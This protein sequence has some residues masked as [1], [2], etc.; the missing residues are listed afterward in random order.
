MEDG[1]DTVRHKDDQG[2]AETSRSY[3]D[4]L[5]IV[6]SIDE[7]TVQAWG[8]NR[9]N[10]SHKQYFLLYNGLIIKKESAL[11][12]PP[13]TSIVRVVVVKVDQ[14]FREPPFSLRKR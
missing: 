8:P 9:C 11:T 12:L 7:V 14:S 1:S 3:R 6:E 10:P 5:E 2:F 4:V 13:A